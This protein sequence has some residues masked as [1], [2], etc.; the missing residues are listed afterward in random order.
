MAYKKY[1]K[2]QWSKAK[3]AARSR[4]TTSTGRGIRVNKIV[5]D[6]AYI[7]RSLNVEHKQVLTRF[8]PYQSTYGPQSPV[9]IAPITNT[10]LA[11][12][13]QGLSNSERVGNNIVVTHISA[14]FEV[15]LSSN[16]AGLN[17][18]PYKV[19]LIFVKA[20]V[21]YDLAGTS[22]P[23]DDLF[24]KDFN[25]SYTQS[26]YRNKD[27][28]PNFIELKG[29]STT[30]NPKFTV[31]D[32]TNSNMLQRFTWNTSCRIPIRFETGNSGAVAQTNKPLLV[33]MSDVDGSTQKTTISG[34]IKLTYIDN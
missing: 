11:L 20:G 29:C 7:K 19:F 9:Q 15:L 13:G 25:G 33:M 10:F 24:D 6:I 14:K 12:P 26:S 8:G 4:Y 34:D 18:Q 17:K 31:G 2:K 32:G 3:S 23:I 5:K 16:V 1:A 27:C 30:A 22:I 21:N 28:Y